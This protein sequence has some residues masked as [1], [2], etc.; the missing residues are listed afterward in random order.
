MAVKRLCSTVFCTGI[1]F[2][3]ASAQPL[4]TGVISGTVVQTESGEAIRKAIVTLTL[5]GTPRRWATTRTDGSGRFQFDGLPA[6]KYDLR[7]AK[8][9]EGSAIYGAK[10]VRELGDAITLGDGESRSGITLKFLRAASIGGRVLDSDGDPV[11][12]AQVSLLQQGRNLG[13]PVPVNYR[14]ANTDDR[15]EY[16]FSDVDPGRYYIRVTPSGVRPAM[17]TKGRPILV[18][19]YYGGARDFKDASPV[20]VSGGDNLVG[21]DFHIVSEPAVT[22]R[23]QVLGVPEELDPPQTP[24]ASGGSFTSRSR[25]FIASTSA[26][27]PRG[28]YVQVMISRAEA[29]EPRFSSGTVAQGPE[30]RFEMPDMPAGRYR[31]EASVQSGAKSY[32]ASEIVDLHPGSG[33]IAL[34]LAPGME[35]QGALRVEGQAAHG[36]GPSPGRPGGIQLERHKPGAFQNNIVAQIG[37]DGHFS[38]GQVFP[39]EWQLTVPLVPHSFLKSARF[40]DKEVRFATFEIGANNDAAFN[41]VVSMRT[42]SV[43]GEIDAGSSEAPRTG[44]VVAPVGQYH[45]FTRFYYAAQTD[46]AGKFHLDGIAPGKYKIFALEKTEAESFRNPEAVDQIDELGETIDLAEG[47]TVQAHPKLIPVDRALKALQ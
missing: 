23:G 29:G 40:G 34:T 42:A 41:I 5:D 10:S 2:V 33:D 37:A 16:R 28:S 35:I 9:N 27:G 6:G 13:A 22:V 26:G 38:F 15:G 19:Q 8:A 45:T 47:A 24:Q 11:S 12:D 17:P 43:E 39:G 30:H 21:L 31:F 18:E 44:I 36:E 25:S 20:H 3:S 7:A 46:A 1:L 14:A 4:G 32:G